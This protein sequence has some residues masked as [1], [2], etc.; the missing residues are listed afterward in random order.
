MI[1]FT[2]LGNHGRLGNQLFQ[3]AFLIGISKK[4]NLPICLP[5][6]STKVAN[7]QLCLLNSYNLVYNCLDIN[8]ISNNRHEI[9]LKSNG[10]FDTY[11]LQNIENVLPGTNFMGLYQSYR[12]WIN[13]QDEVKKQFTIKDNKI[14][15]QAKQVLNKLRTATNLPIT[16]I[17]L[18]RG[19]VT[20]WY[21]YTEYKQYLKNVLK[22][23]KDPKNNFYYI[24]TGGSSVLT[25]DQEDVK[26]VKDFYSEL[27]HFEI[28]QSYNPIMDFALMQECDQII[29]GYIS[30]FAWWA[31]FL[32]GKTIYAPKI[33]NKG[34]DL[35]LNYYPD[36]F[37][38]F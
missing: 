22:T 37:N 31:A 11:N 17:H 14:V 23:F 20:G 35:R 27:P 33:F 18:R 28:C 25:G 3:Y 15:E 24:F 7:N 12:Y 26:W 36:N 2:E 10:I 34:D 6:L 1:T 5:D 38:L 19:D 8:Y 21:D 13:Y 4:Y 16:A 29:L 32:S 30:T 9:E